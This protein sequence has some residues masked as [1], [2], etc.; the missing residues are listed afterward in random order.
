MHTELINRKNHTRS[1]CHV[2]WPT[3]LSAE[4]MQMPGL[5]K[6]MNQKWTRDQQTTFWHK[7]STSLGRKKLSRENEVDREQP[8]KP[9]PTG[10]SGLHLEWTC[11]GRKPE[12]TWN[13]FGM[14]EL[15]HAYIAVVD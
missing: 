6:I 4:N 8:W 10:D 13:I 1:Q 15:G 14:G 5:W 9:L 3:S 12:L 7:V 2:P 11:E